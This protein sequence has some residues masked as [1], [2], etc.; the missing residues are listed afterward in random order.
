MLLLLIIILIVYISMIFITKH[1]TPI[2]W[3]GS[4][5][6]L[7]IGAASSL[8]DAGAAF[9]KFPSEIIVLI[10][11][12][13][14][15]T[16]MFRKLGLINYIGH[17]FVTL[18]KENRVI[19]IVAMP[20]LMYATS[21][22]MNNLTVVLLYTY[23]ALYL[24]I[25]Y[26]LPP[27]PLFVSIIIG[28][29]IG[30]AALPWADTPA[31][32]LTLYTDFS[33]P[34]FINK[35]FVPCLAYAAALSLYSYL[36]YKH[37]SPKIRGL[38]FNKTPDVDWKKLKPVLM[39]FMLYIA[40]VSVG[41]LI[42]ISI[43]YI[44]LLFGGILLFISKIDPMDA[45]NELPIVD[46]IAFIIALFLIGGVLEYSGILK[47]A[48]EY[49]VGFTNQNAYLVALAVLYMAFIISTFLSA[50]PAAATL[51]PIC[52][53]LERL[54]PFK[55]IYAALALGI[56]AGSSMLPWSATGGPILLSQI[57]RFI[58]HHHL[59]MEDTKHIREIFSL[60]SYLIFS[61]PFSLIILAASEVY[62]LIFISCFH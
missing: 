26:Q 51:L 5:I 10:I 23:M 47:I 16:E 13:S 12:L 31:V 42:N 44:S 18:T 30:G 41:P 55:L 57:N 36:W 27:V 11:V 35:L 2:A 61:V 8:F 45:L 38:P 62:L 28:S 15:Y 46:S 7:T 43:A 52:A 20:L 29:N 33:L 54:V 32:V 22:F 9:F 17:K 4:G 37:F 34:D 49:I 6:L 59:N 24:A 25:E 40:M 58:Q 1:R 53:A 39:L 60:K 50:G 19:I 3:V 14:L 48:T 56:L 21:L